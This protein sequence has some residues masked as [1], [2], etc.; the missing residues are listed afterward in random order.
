MKFEPI[1]KVKIKKFADDF[2]YKT[3]DENS[4]FERY[5]NNLI[6]NMHHPDSTTKNSSLLEMA[7]VGG[8]ND[9][10]IDG[11]AI[12][13]NGIIVTSCKEIKDITDTS[14]Q[15]SVEF[16]FVQS[17][18][19]NK[20]DS[21][22]YSKFADGVYDFLST[23]HFEPHN[24]KIDE[25]I[26][27][28][29][30]IFSEDIMLFWKD[31]PIVTA[32]YVIFGEW[33]EDAHIEGK[34]KA[35]NEKID[36]LN[37]YS[38]FS[39]KFLGSSDIAR[40]SDDNENSFKIVLNVLGSL[41]FEE[42]EDVSNSQVILCKATDFVKLL[43]TEEGN[44]R[45]SLFSDNVR[46]YQGNTNINE[47]MLDTIEN[48][49]SSF[50]LLNNGITIVCSSLLSGNR[51]VT[52]ENPQIVN[53]CQTSNVIYH[54]HSTGTDL[55]NVA[56]LVKIIATD[57]AR[58]TNSI[59]RGTNSQNP[60]FSESFEITRDFH[61]N[62][63]DFL[64]AIQND[65]QN[66]EKIFYERR[67][68]QYA[69]DPLVKKNRIFSLDMLAHS[70]ISVFLHSPHDGVSHIV[71]LLEKYRNTIFVDSQSLYPYYC[72]ALLCLNFERLIREEIIERKYDTYKYFL[73]MMLAERVA[74]QHLD[75]NNRNIDELCSK[76]INCCNSRESLTEETLTVIASFEE[77]MNKWINKYG[78]KYKHG[79]KDNPA[80]TRFLLT[81][82]R[83]GNVDKLEPIETQEELTSSGV[84]I[85]AKQDRAGRYYGF[86]KAFPDNMFF[87]SEDNPRIDFTRIIGETVTYQK[88][89]NPVNGKPKAKNVRVV[90][91]NT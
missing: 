64:V 12:K 19:K 36:A 60:V 87:H 51:K 68:K 33:R 70:V 28:K 48:T 38:D 72:S 55:S 34:N 22:E 74:K 78:L 50:L 53:G 89:T 8:Q 6:L 32:Y 77:I 69:L 14:K 73:I 18:F 56:L 25:W 9:M 90:S 15:I 24:D 83:G 11:L 1:L 2:G 81:S 21:G 31:A 54:A 42:V 39:C 40:I 84:V 76:I 35:L 29:D 58:I 61:K 88:S 62:L 63:E 26:A 71:N 45:R 86:I 85:S 30:Y 17:K 66:D 52:I 80:F 91:E 44:I 82:M 7:S 27:L 13:I 57:E 41:E 10:G 65:L 20:I 37:D 67:S 5:I 75:I 4:L 43:L 59:V 49:P 47:G 16:I 3:L 79:I 23:K 46:D